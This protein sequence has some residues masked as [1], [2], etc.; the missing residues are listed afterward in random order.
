MVFDNAKSI[1]NPRGMNAQE[2][3]E[4]VEELNQLDNI[5]ISITSC[6]FT[7]SPDCVYLDVPTLSVGAAHDTFYR[8]YSNGH[9]PGAIDSIFKQLDFHPLSITLFAT[10]AH[11]NRW[12]TSPLAG[13]WEGRKTS[14]WYSH[15]RQTLAAAIELSVASPLFREPGPRRA[16]FSVPLTSSRKAPTR[17][18]LNGYSPNL[19]QSQN[20]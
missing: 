14:V 19:R 12:D 1:L 10:V 16:R 6:I 5:R 20:L 2:T 11:Q 13:E 7:T 9:R 3:Y 4:L 15:H 18:T 17:T 8:I